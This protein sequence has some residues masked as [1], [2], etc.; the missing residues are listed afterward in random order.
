MAK[1]RP[2]CA[3][4]GGFH[5]DPTPE[6]YLRWTQFG[7]LSP[8]YRSHGTKGSNRDYWSPAYAS[9]F[10]LI[11]QSLALRLALAPY[12]GSKYSTPEPSRWVF[13]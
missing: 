10:P 11:K 3:Q 4:I 9:V 7:A 8:M 5:G 1:K 6:L 2:I 13:Q 12:L